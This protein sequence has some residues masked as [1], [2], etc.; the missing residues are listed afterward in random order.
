MAAEHTLRPSMLCHEDHGEVRGWVLDLGAEAPADA[1]PIPSNLFHGV[2]LVRCEASEA[3]ALALMQAGDATRQALSEAVHAMACVPIAE[4]ASWERCRPCRVPSSLF[5]ARR[6]RDGRVTFEDGGH[7]PILD[8]AEWAPE[9]SPDGFVGL[10]FLWSSR[11]GRLELY[12]ACQSYLPLACAEFARMVFRLRGSCRAR[13]V[14]QSEEAQWL[15]MA[16]ARNRARVLARVCLAVGVRAPMI[17]DYCGGGSPMVMA[18]GET[19]HHDLFA[20]NDG[21]VRV[22]N[23]CCADERESVCCMAPWEGLWLVHSGSI[24][25]TAA[26]RLGARVRPFSFTSAP[27]RDS[28]VLCEWVEDDADEA[29]TLLSQ[30]ELTTR[31]GLSDRNDN[32]DEDLVRAAYRRSL[33]LHPPQ[34]VNES[35]VAH[36]LANTHQQPQ[37]LLFDEAVTQRVGWTRGV[38]KLLPFGVVNWRAP[39][40]SAI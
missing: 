37:Y 19:L 39:P 38:V 27:P 2:T 14:A 15:R 9:L 36:A 32:A 12:A 26:P 3:E 16:C 11:S 24:A 1:L 10:Y 13:F 25:P 8:G 31:D 29:A 40:S 21:R 23:Y 22:L 7:V 34:S 20:L 35:V 6:D 28:R 18:H 30:M 4:Q 17:D 33:L 5:T